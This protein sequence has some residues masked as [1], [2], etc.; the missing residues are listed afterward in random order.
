MNVALTKITRPDAFD[1]NSTKYECDWAL[2]TDRKGAGL[3]VRFDPAQRH[4]CRAGKN[5]DGYTLAVN[6][7]VCPPQDIS[8]KVVPDLYL[9]LNPG[10]VLEA[11]FT[12][13]SVR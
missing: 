7:Q 9:T 10:D 3:M 11:S 8:S 12:V 4:Q 2:L 5:A 1:F 13:G 6:K